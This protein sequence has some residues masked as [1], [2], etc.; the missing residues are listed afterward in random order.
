MRRFKQKI[1]VVREVF[2][3][4]TL[5]LLLPDETGDSLK[6]G[7]INTVLPI[8][9]ISDC[10]VLVDEAP[11]FSILVK[12]KIL[13]QLGI[14]IEIGRTKNVNKNPTAERAVQE[15]EKEFK[16]LLPAG[17]QISPGTLA[18]ATSNLNNKIRFNGLSA[19][20]IL[21]K[22]DQFTGHDLDFNGQDIAANRKEKNES[23]HQSSA[24][25][26][27]KGGPN[28]TLA[29]VCEGDLVHVKKKGDKHLCRD[30]YLV[31][32]LCDTEYSI[33]NKFVGNQLRAKE[34]KVKLSEIYPV[35]SV[36]FRHDCEDEESDTDIDIH[37]P[38]TPPLRRSTRA[39]KQ[40]QFYVAQ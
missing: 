16:R 35:T 9:H 27:S 20:E 15:V 5:T 11:G 38:K 4:F 22:R 21:T 24:I 32:K 19:L 10:I 29:N 39:R 31:K 8:K 18:I 28:A 13:N 33:L 40:T 23:N 34:Y 26:K 37:I 36:S 7:L 1:L 14:T 3:S 2:S 30:I 12:D 25:S 6:E 17:G